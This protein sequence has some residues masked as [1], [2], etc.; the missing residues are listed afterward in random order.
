MKIVKSEL[1]GSSIDGMIESLSSDIADTKKLST[2]IDNFINEISGGYNLYGDSY[3]KVKDK[4]EAY[5]SILSERESVAT[6][7]R[8]AINDAVKFMNSFMGEYDVV[9]DSDVLELKRM[10]AIEIKNNYFQLME[11]NQ[12]LDIL[13][14]EKKNN[15]QRQIDNLEGIISFLE[16]EIKMKEELVPKDIQAYSLLES[17]KSQISQYDAKVQSMQGS[18][19]VEL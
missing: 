5:K 14:G 16:K 2:S 18:Q 19:I 15:L 8:N 10:L 7:L 3:Q 6:N 12:T 1:S 4:L 11:K 17:V 9:D 13:S